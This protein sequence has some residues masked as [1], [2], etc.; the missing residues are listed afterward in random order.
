MASV[1]PIGRNGLGARQLLELDACT[2]CGQCVKVCPSFQVT[3]DERGSM[4]GMV[5]GRRQLLSQES[6]FLR[7]LLRRASLPEEAWG[8]FQKGV[9]AC[10]LCGR[11]EQ[12]CPVG[13]RTRSLALSMREELVTARCMLPK[14]LDVARDAALEEGNIFRFPNE[15]RAM[16]AEF[17]DDL[18]NDWLVKERAEVLYYVGCVSSFSPAVQEIPQAFLQVLLKADVDIALLGGRE[19]CCGFPLIVGG[20]RRHAEKLIEHNMEEVHRLGVKTIVFNCPSCFY[21]WSKYYPL[22]GIRLL[23]STQFIAELVRSGSLSFE[24]SDLPVTYHDPCDLGR[25]MGEYGAPR[26][27][28]ASF[29]GGNY[30]ELTPSQAQALCCGGGGDV[31]MWD[32]DLVD[33][34][35]ALLTQAVEES[36]AKLLVQACPQCK[37]ATRRRLDMNCSEIRTM[38]IVELALEFGAFNASGARECQG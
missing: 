27:V 20:F 29:A 8:E 1:I 33:G 37:R 38:D 3:R 18:P 31:E 10:T 5:Q 34:I 36:G 23:H 4:M 11:C 25:G 35:N 15:E 9:F 6:S 16:W 21:T 19:W 7:Q 14:N 28:L 24:R 13:I 32:P 22:Q 17:L 30:R 26:E 2:R 12:S